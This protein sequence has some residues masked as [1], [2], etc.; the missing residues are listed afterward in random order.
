V[1]PASP[2]AGCTSRRLAEEGG[3]VAAQG[4]ASENDT[5]RATVQSRLDEIPLEDLAIAAVRVIHHEV[6]EPTSFCPELKSH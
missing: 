4:P 3:V 2:R 6:F 1:Q 5:S